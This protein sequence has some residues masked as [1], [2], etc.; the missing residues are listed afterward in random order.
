MST[1]GELIFRTGTG[2]DPAT[3][4][5]D[6]LV[7]RPFVQWLCD[8]LAQKRAEVEEL[9]GEL[10][11]TR[12]ALRTAYRALRKSLA[13]LERHDQARRRELDHL[14]AMVSAFP[15]GEA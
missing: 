4:P 3:A 1:R 5:D 8:E 10:R 14:D 9:R 2:L 12:R 11:D 15:E 13:A 7:G 6:F